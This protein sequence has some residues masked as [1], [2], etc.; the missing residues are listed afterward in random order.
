MKMKLGRASVPVYC[1]YIYEAINWWNF[2]V[3]YFQSLTILFGLMHEITTSRKLI[4]VRKCLLEMNYDEYLNF[5]EA[6]NLLALFCSESSHLNVT[7][8]RFDLIDDKI[9]EKKEDMY[10]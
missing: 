4:H 5:G 1:N 7:N 8:P 2:Q 3:L 10:L 9:D 6:G